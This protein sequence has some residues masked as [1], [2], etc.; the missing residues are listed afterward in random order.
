MRSSIRRF[1]LPSLRY[2]LDLYNPVLRLNNDW[3]D[4]GLSIDVS[5]EI[6]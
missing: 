2:G 5:G 1:E 4:F 6:H 3:V